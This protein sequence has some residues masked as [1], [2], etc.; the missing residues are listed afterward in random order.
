MVAGPVRQLCA[1]VNEMDQFQIGYT[2]FSIF[3]VIGAGL[4][5]FRA[6]QDTCRVQ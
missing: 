1:F 4:A 2:G 5:C 3:R 6:T